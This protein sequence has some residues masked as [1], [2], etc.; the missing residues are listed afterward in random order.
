MAGDEGRRSGASDAE[1]RLLQRLRFIAGAVI[2]ACIVFLVV[3]D[4]IGRLFVS[5][6]FHVSELILG[7]LVGALLVVLG[8]E[9][10]TRLPFGGGRNGR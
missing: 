5:P 8:I 7:T 10:V 1:D 2:L 4:P 6:D 9:G 3:I